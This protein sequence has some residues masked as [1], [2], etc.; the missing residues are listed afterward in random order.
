MHTDE[1]QALTKLLRNDE[2]PFWTGL[3]RYLKS[4]SI[5][6]AASYLVYSVEL[7]MRTEFGVVVTPEKNVYSFAVEIS[8][9]DATITEE[10][11]WQNI[12]ATYPSSPYESNI[13]SALELLEN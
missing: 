1:V 8:P 3:R 7:S 4:K 9:V 10:L 2:G 6:P 5:D 12:T 13:V 11:E